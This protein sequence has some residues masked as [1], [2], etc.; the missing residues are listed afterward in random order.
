[1]AESRAATYDAIGRG[2]DTTRRADSRIVARVRYHLDPVPGERYLDIGCGTGNYTVAL[3][4]TGVEVIG[5][6]A[7][8]VMLDAARAKAPRLEWCKGFAEELPFADSTFD[9]ALCI[10]AIHH[11]TDIAS[12]FGEVRRVLRG[13]RF[14]VFTATPEQMQGYWLNHY[15]PQAVARGTAQMLK[16]DAIDAALRNAGFDDVHSEPFDVSPDFVDLF[17]Y[18][19]KQRPELYLDARVRA[20]ISTFAALADADEVARGVVALEA[21]IVSGAID[22]VVARFDDSAGD[23]LFV[24]AE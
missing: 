23:Y 16:L 5:V 9:G 13:G 21:D 15:F 1:M 14:V 11:F 18:A 22:E 3:A 20:G 6:D 19:G 7:S 8:D 10:V 24:I 12:A 17:L 2:Y 4:E